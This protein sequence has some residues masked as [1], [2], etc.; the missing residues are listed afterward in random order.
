MKKLICILTTVILL[1]FGLAACANTPSSD[2]DKE[3]TMQLYITVG[4][5]RLT[6]ELEENAATAAL[7]ERLKTAPLTIDMSDYGGWEKVGYF[8]FDLPTSNRQITA[9]PCDFVLYQ[10][11]QLVIFYCSNSW[12]YTKLGK[13]TGI[14]ADE[15]L[16]VL[17]SGDTSVTLSVS[18]TGE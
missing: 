3:E 8:G 7:C 6:T 14:S 2:G 9:Q 11:N 18:S 17:G 4:D 12:S 13:I 10:G 1:V 16:A 15:L 5:T